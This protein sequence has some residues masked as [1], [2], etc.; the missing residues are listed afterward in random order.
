MGEAMASESLD[1]KTRLILAGE[2]LFAK[3]GI[4]GASMREIAAR[5]GQG[6]HAAVQYHFKSRDGLVRAI[7]DYRM[8]QMEAARG[9]MLERAAAQGRLDD[10]RTILEIVLLPQLDLHDADGNHSYASFLSQYLL[11]SRSPKFGDF[12][13]S[14]PPHLKQ[15]LELLRQ[16]VSYLPSQVAQR[17]LISVSLMFLNILVRHHGTEETRFEE[18]FEDALED[19]MEQIVT[20]MCMPLRLSARA[21]A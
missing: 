2:Q 8:E 20:V 10:A 13:G 12:S 16:R 21:D 11:Q 19:T 14:E 15:S 1:A 3:G 9:A 7:F 4:N 5:A 17:R 18:T 6:N